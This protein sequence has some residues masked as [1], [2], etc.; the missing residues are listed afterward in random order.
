MGF[1]DF[2][3]VLIFT[4]IYG[5]AIRGDSTP[6][7]Y[8]DPR[9]DLIP[10]LIWDYW[11]FRKFKK[12]YGNFVKRQR[13][14]LYFRLHRRLLEPSYRNMKFWNFRAVTPIREL[15]TKIHK[16]FHKNVFPIVIFFTSNNHRA[17]SLTASS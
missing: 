12:F 15:W 5:L 11:K 16:N 14:L 8:T 10:A 6:N 7:K 17:S 4:L 13:W 1:A 9:W 2:P 3:E